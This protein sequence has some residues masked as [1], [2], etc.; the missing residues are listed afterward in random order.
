MPKRRMQ[1]AESKMLGLESTE[2]EEEALASDKRGNGRGRK[3]FGFYMNGMNRLTLRLLKC[4]TGRLTAR[5]MDKP[6]CA[7]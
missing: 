2:A 3:M 5:Q 6:N 7:Q 1:I 4:P